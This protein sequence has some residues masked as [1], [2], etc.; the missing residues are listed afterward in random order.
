VQTGARVIPI[1]RQSDVLQKA[2]KNGPGELVVKVRAKDKATW[3][4][5]NLSLSS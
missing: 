1:G 3:K 5:I 4:A 2:V